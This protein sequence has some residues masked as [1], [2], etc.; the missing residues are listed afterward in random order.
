[1]GVRQPSEIQRQLSVVIWHR[2]LVFVLGVLMSLIYLLPSS[3]CF[4][5]KRKRLGF[6]QL[7]VVAVSPYFL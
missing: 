5:F 3:R 6:G 2:A 4:N 7:A 1:M